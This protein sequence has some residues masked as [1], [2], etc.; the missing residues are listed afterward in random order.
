M[1]R[2]RPATRPQFA[3]PELGALT[4]FGL[5]KPRPHLPFIGLLAIAG[6]AAL[7]AQVPAPMPAQAD[8]DRAVA[9]LRQAAAAQAPAGARIEVLPG[10][11]DPR[12][13]LADCARTEP[14][15]APGAP[16]WG[17]TRVGLRC[18]QGAV[19]WTVWWPATVQVW[20]DA[21]VPRGALPAGSVLTEGDLVRGPVDWAAASTPPLAN[22]K[23]AAGR[24]LARHVEPGQAL[25]PAD[26]RVRQ[27]FAGGDTV[28]LVATGAGFS[29]GGEAR[30]LTPGIEGQPVRVITE[31]G[32][33]LVGRPVGERRVEVAL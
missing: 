16:V 31:Q 6:P 18:A 10:A 25:R 29:I 32:R 13:K 5:V 3:A 28:Q 21:A 22:I 11:A 12:L 2:I 33:T 19:A 23:D 15:L 24:T 14:H 27:W 8:L 1:S 9:L 26:L 30:A 17:R 4:T 7:F 20:A